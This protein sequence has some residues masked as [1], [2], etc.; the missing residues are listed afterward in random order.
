MLNPPLAYPDIVVATS[1]PVTVALI[2]INIDVPAVIGIL[3]PVVNPDDIF[4]TPIDPVNGGANVPVAPGIA[5]N[6]LL[7]V[8][9]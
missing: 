3:N 4:P 8:V 7:G 9:D 5:V 6:V 2:N 1:T